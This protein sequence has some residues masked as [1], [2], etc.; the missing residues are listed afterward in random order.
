MWCGERLCE[1]SLNVQVSVMVDGNHIPMAVTVLEKLDIDFL[2]GLDMLRRHRCSIDL[3]SN[4]LRFG[5]LDSTSL[6]FLPEHELPTS[7]N[8]GELIF[9]GS[10]FREASDAPASVS[11]RMVALTCSSERQQDASQ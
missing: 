7:A 5:T 4:C 6:E 1:L 8:N 9:S 10:R 11:T 2:F 3:A